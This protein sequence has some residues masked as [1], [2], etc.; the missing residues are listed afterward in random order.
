M[1]RSSPR[2]ASVRP[3]EA[4]AIIR[5]RELSE[6]TKQLMRLDEKREKLI[7]EMQQ[8]GFETGYIPY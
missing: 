6:M 8:K 5:E 1:I 3:I 7:R 4:M 2:G